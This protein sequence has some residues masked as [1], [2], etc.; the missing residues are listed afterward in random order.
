MNCLTS[1]EIYKKEFFELCFKEEKLKNEKLKEKIENTKT[2]N[3]I[4][5]LI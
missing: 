4:K 5:G 1:E 3:K 2:I